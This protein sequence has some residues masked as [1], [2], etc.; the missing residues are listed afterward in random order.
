MITEMNKR[1][2]TLRARAKRQEET[3][4]RIAAAAAALHEEL[5]PRDASISAIAE[6]AGV[7]RLTVYR[8]FP[9]LASLFEACSTH[10]LGENPPPDPRTWQ[11]VPDAAERTRLALGALYRYYR[12]TE[13][14]WTYVYRDLE[15]LPDLQGPMGKFEAYLDSIRDDLL[16]T[17]APPREL[18]RRL[19]IVLGHG[20]SF[21]TW[22]SLRGEGMRDG[23][24]A[25]LVCG[26]V[27][28]VLSG[29]AA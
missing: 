20:V 22:R 18:R 16:A 12:R 4:S 27:E 26:W 11:S 7:Q 6:R 15:E 14:L 13:R 3:R 17:W 28:S 2:Y 21:S 5:G 23:E 25:A 10:W 19:R 8:H 9:D 29:V 1:T 24:M